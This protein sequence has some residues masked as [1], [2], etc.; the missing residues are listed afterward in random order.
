MRSLASK[1]SRVLLK[2]SERVVLDGPRRRRLWPAARLA[3]ALNAGPCPPCFRTCPSRSR[4][5]PAGSDR[6]S[7]HPSPCAAPTRSSP[8]RAAPRSRAARR[9]S[10]PGRPR[11]LGLRQAGV[12]TQ[13][14]ARVQPTPP[15]DRRAKL[16]SKPAL[17]TYVEERLPG[18]IVAPGGARSSARSAISSGRVRGEMLRH[19]QPIRHGRIGLTPTSL[20]QT[21]RGHLGRHIQRII[22][23][24]PLGRSSRF[25]ICPPQALARLVG[26]GLIRPSAP[27]AS[28]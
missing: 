14:S 15:V 17:R 2:P 25:R 8:R 22:R 9:A 26:Q 27:A 6:P 7:G 11:C 28:S 10:N 13:D 4:P 23:P 20:R 3:V 16:V 19:A 5:D 18:I 1:V 21:R 24:T 12:G